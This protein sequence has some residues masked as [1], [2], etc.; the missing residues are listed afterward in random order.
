VAYIQETM[1]AV[2]CEKLKAMED[3]ATLP[4][5]LAC[6]SNETN[7]AKFC[8]QVPNWKHGSIEGPNALDRR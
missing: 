5:D 2:I 3:K 8:L 1:Q 6:W 7:Y 4:T